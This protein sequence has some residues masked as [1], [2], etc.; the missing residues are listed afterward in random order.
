MNVLGPCVNPAE[1]G[2]QLLGVADPRLLEP[3]A[4]TL[5]ALGV[6][7]ALVVHGAGL[8]EIALNGAT[9]QVRLIDGRPEPRIP[10]T[11]E[12]RPMREPVRTP[13]GGGGEG[14][15]AREKRGG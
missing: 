15:R 2:V 11:E 6:E 5:A 3:V 1:P 13:K 4:R 12:A 7:R 8:D 14:E 9:H 10:L